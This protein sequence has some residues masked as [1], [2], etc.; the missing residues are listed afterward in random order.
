MFNFNRHFQALAAEVLDRCWNEDRLKTSELLVR[1]SH[2]WGGCTTLGLA[3]R[4]KIEDFMAES[5]CASKL[6]RIMYGNLSVT[7][8]WYWVRF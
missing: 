3:Y 5:A 6:Q 1:V 7:T 4:G 2:C 8:T